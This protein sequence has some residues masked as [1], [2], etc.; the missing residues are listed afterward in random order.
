MKYK[1]LKSINKNANCKKCFEANK[2]RKACHND[3]CIFFNK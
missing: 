1:S 3:E 2:Y